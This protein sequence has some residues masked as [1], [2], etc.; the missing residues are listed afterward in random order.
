MK[1]L[2][3]GYGKWACLSLRALVGAGYEV[4]GAVCD[5]EEVD[6]ERQAYYQKLE[7]EE[8]FE[9]L[10]S[11][12][13]EYGISVLRPYDVNS[14]EFYL[15]SRELHT[16]I[17]ASCGYRGI[18]KKPLLLAYPCINVHGALL[19]H[20]RGRAPAAW[21]L[22]NGETQSGVTV[23]YMSEMV[24]S[25][26]IICQEGFEISTTDTVADVLRKGLP[27]YPKL[28]V[29]AVS[30]IASDSVIPQPQ[31]PYAGSYFPM[32]TEAD[33][34]IDWTRSSTDV[35]NLIRAQSS[36]YPGAYTYVGA[37]RIGVVKAS[38][39]F[40]QRRI[41]PIPGLVFGRCLDGTVLVTTGDGYVHLT[42]I[43]FRGNSCPASQWIRVGQRF[44]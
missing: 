35:F 6:K 17:I 2:L 13:Q 11:V 19:P 12:A 18:L 21:V 23:H 37:E 9:S 28:L 44:K 26:D 42:E 15:R 24:D 31:D 40:N 5:P 14:D 38:L 36:P 43:D 33:S 1:T 39:P 34:R 29:E 22:L 20:Y 8:L 10:P 16:Q 27:L 25:G 41:S 3:M 30:M 32:L 7:K 4:V